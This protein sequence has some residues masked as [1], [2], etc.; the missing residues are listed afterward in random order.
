M[1][2]ILAECEL[3]VFSKARLVHMSAMITM[4]TDHL[5]SLFLCAIQVLLLMS[6]GAQHM[7]YGLD[8]SDFG[9][10]MGMGQLDTGLENVAEASGM[11][12]G[13]VVS[14]GTGAFRG[15]AAKMCWAAGYLLCNLLINPSNW[16]GVVGQACT[17]RKEYYLLAAI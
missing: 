12:F 5:S 17:W 7:N 9:L 2:V 16:F 14:E 13:S 3:A 4:I 10:D 1:F 11:G 6:A 15:I 8:Q